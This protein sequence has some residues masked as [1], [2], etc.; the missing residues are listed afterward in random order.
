MNSRY[1]A[2]AALSLALASIATAAEEPE[3][4]ATESAVSYLS[5][6][7]DAQYS[8]AWEALAT[9]LQAEASS[10]SFARQ[11]VSQRARLGKLISRTQTSA[12][13]DGE[14]VVVQFA[15]E[16]AKFR[17]ATETVTLLFAPDGSWKVAKHTL[18]FYSAGVRSRR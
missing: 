16:H 10:E 15:V 3:K 13:L 2:C 9:G 6:I 14:R 11:M 12:K 7:D 8:E 17:Q 1:L 18:D 4:V 5:L